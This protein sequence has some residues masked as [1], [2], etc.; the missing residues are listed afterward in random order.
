[1]T[2]EQHRTLASKD[3]YSSR[4]GYGSG[5]D[6]K[7]ITYHKDF[8]EVTRSIISIDLIENSISQ[9]LSA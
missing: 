8:G 7:V 4:G 9:G 2:I 5:R 3:A 6:S 1:M